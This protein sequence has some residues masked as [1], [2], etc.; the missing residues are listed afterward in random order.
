MQNS[1][2][3]RPGWGWAPHE[4]DPYCNTSFGCQNSSR[5]PKPT[6]DL[7]ALAR[8]NPEACA[9]SFM[10]SDHLTYEAEVC[11]HGERA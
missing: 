11:C 8:S 6:E 9:A 10:C 7:V 1:E 4:P 3:E 5:A 2:L